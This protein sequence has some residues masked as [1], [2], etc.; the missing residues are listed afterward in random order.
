MDGGV[1][2]GKSRCV[3]RPPGPEAF[4]ASRTTVCLRA[5]LADMLG[6]AAMNRTLRK[7]DPPRRC[8]RDM[9]KETWESEGLAYAGELA[10]R[11]FEDLLAILR[12]NLEHDIRFY[13]CSSTLVPW[14][15]RFDLPEL[16][17]FERVRSLARECG[18]LVREHDVR[19]TFHP[20]HWFDILPALKGEDSRPQLGY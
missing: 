4:T 12:W 5:E 20:S 7:R 16:P 6:Y 9:R 19:L 15:S 8:N 13:R 14:N 10:A 2:V 18:R 1:Q 17:N 3:K 11:N